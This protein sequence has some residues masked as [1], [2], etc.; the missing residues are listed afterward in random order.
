MSVLSFSCAR[1]A[2]PQP[3]TKEA[4]AKVAVRTRTNLGEPPCL[5]PVHVYVFDAEGQCVDYRML[6]EA[7]EPLSLSLPA[8]MY[9]VSA[10]TGISADRYVIPKLPDA[11]TASPLELI[12]PAGGHVQM[13]AG[14]ACISLVDGENQE[15][16]LTVSRVVS[17]IRVSVFGLP[18]GVTDVKMSVQP[19][20]SV[21]RIDGLFDEVQS[22]T[23]Q[24]PLV[25]SEEEHCW[26]TEDSLFIFPGTANVT[27]G[28][29]LT[30]SDGEHSYAG[31]TP[32]EIIANYKYNI[33]ATYKAGSVDIS[34][35]VTGTDWEGEEQCEFNFG[36]DYRVGDF[37][38]N[39]FIFHVEKEDGNK[40]MLYLLSPKQWECT[41]TIGVK[42]LLATY[43]QYGFSRWEIPS[44]DDARKLHELCKNIK[45][46]NTLLEQQGSYPL[47]TD[48]RYFCMQGDKIVHFP[49]SGTFETQTVVKKAKYRARFLKKVLIQYL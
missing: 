34:G 37:Y 47:L 19:L 14:Q 8:G 36:S 48:D 20:R 38:R 16:A 7:G 9:T 1:D 18:E 32:F 28:I 10:L 33:L 43:S 39:C 49:L 44:E 24:I 41:D 26:K 31:N 27:V 29:V 2:V 6:T 30:D 40:A 25:K 23:A 45:Q 11:R 42:N 5:L 4:T 15:L 13:E 3:G 35:V 21:L 22:G 46:I 12:D 17:Q